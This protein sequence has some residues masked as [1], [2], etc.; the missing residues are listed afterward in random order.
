VIAVSEG[1]VTPDSANMRNFYDTV[2][3]FS[4]PPDALFLFCMSISS[5]EA[6][7]DGF[8]TYDG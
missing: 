1:L 5:S 2:L 6:R 7:S 4:Q 3:K 8:G